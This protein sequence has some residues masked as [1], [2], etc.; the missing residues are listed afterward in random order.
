[1]G[2]INTMINQNKDKFKSFWSNI[3][4]FSKIVTIGIST[5]SL[6]LFVAIIGGKNATIVFSLLQ[7]VAWIIS[8]L[9][10][11]GYIK[12]SKR[13]L[14]YFVLAFSIVIFILSIKSFS[15]NTSQKGTI[16]ENNSPNITTV[17]D[18]K[19]NENINSNIEQ[20]EEDTNLFEETQLNEEIF[21]T[22]E[23]PLT[24]V[25]DGKEHIVGN[26]SIT[27]QKI[28]LV[29]EPF[30]S[31]PGNPD[32]STYSKYIRI[33]AT[34]KNNSSHETYLSARKTGTYFIGQ[35]YGNSEPVTIGWNN[36]FK[37]KVNGDIKTDYGWNLAPHETKDIYISGVFIDESKLKYTDTPKLD[38]FFVNDGITL[39]ISVN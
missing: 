12:A 7:I 19:T 13:Y 15:W 5:S 39:T 8:I 11:K 27:L 38:L 32:K 10:H 36:N 30:K 21:V 35:Y 37:W 22:I 24:L 14:K 2:I 3:D 26:C 29:H 4:I 23:R 16:P 17:S 33:H 31:Y 9:L 25:F 20:N 1:M 34:V 6:F 18:N 28:E